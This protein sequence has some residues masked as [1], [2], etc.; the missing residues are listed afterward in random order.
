MLILDSFSAHVG[1]DHVKWCKQH[2]VYLVIIPGGLTSAL[3]PL[4]LR[5]NAPY[6]YHL[7]EAM[8]SWVEIA[9]QAAASARDKG[10]FPEPGHQDFVTMAQVAWDNVAP[11]N[12]MAGFKG[13]GMGLALD[14]TE[15]DW[16]I[17]GIM[18]DEF[19]AKLEEQRRRTLDHE[20]RALQAVGNDGEGGR[21]EGDARGA[22]KAAKETE[23][24]P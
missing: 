8:Y 4:D 17:G 20:Q 14:G 16:V 23:D 5:V 9:R 19:D 11:E 18:D 6:K 24:P 10:G 3:Q 7:R 12:V 21:Q 22:H 13:A 15:D 2:D 1:E